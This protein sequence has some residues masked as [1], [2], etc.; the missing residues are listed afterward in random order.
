[1]EKAEGIRK[2]LGDTLGLVPEKLWE[3]EETY[4]IHDDSDRVK[5]AV[6]AVVVALFAVLER[7]VDELTKG[8]GR[9]S[10]LSFQF[11]VPLLATYDY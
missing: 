2:E 5:L 10:I 11:R 8:F 6:D 7:M 4:I 1:M 3:I 9:R